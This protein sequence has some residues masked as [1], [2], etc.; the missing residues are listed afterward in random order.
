[1]T[2]YRKWYCTCTG[3]PI[4][5]TYDEIMKTNRWCRY[6]NSA[7]RLHPRIQ[8]KPSSIAT[9]KTGTTDGSDL[10]HHRAGK[11]H[12]GHGR[13]LTGFAHGELHPIILPPLEVHAFRISCRDSSVTRLVSTTLYSTISAFTPV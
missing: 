10:F 12:K 2:V 3:E 1:M 8:K 11:K 6:A 5:L 4:E 7:V 13:A 9:R